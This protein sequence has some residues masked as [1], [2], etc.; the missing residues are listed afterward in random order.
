MRIAHVIGQAIGGGVE[1]VVLNYYKNI[2]RERYQFD[3]FIDTDSTVDFKKIVEPYGGRV[4]VIPPYRKAKEYIGELEKIFRQNKYKIVHSHMNTLSVFTLYA[5]KKAGV[6]I[7]IAHN[8]STAGKGE[9]KKNI[10]KYMLRPFAKMNAT[11]YAACSRYAGEW[12]FGKKSVENGEVTIFNNGIDLEKFK[13]NEDVRNAVRSKFDI[14]NKFV[15]GHIGRFCYQKNHDFLIEIFEDV[16][17]KRSNSV[18]MLVGEGK[19]LGEVKAKVKD[20]GLGDCVMFLGNRNDVNE[21]YQAMDVFVLPSRYEGLGMVAV[22]AQAAQLKTIVSTKV[23]ND[24]E[25]TKNIKFLDLSMHSGIWADNILVNDKTILIE[26]R[27][28]KFDIKECVKKLEE[29]YEGLGNERK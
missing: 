2:D 14:E 21:L 9:Y 12:L 11:D 16:H 24:V 28:K 20:R 19:L 8:H 3:F 6:P 22:E 15:V 25:I 10:M 17:K 29:F 23:P 7:R 13:Y 4:Y 1:S 27:L 26:D 18:L 5:A